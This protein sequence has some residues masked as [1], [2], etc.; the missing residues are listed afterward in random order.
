V[1]KSTSEGASEVIERSKLVGVTIWGETESLLL[2]RD[3]FIEVG[4]VA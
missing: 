1:L 4:D 3:R 2:S